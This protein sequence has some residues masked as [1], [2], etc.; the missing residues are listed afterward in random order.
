MIYLLV[1]TTYLLIT[2]SDSVDGNNISGTLSQNVIPKLGSD[3]INSVN[4]DVL[5]GLININNIPDNLN[6][7][8]NPVNDSLIVGLNSSK[9]IG[10]I[11]LDQIVDINFSMIEGVV[12]NNQVGTIDSSKLIGLINQSNIPNITTNKIDGMLN[13]D[14][15]PDIPVDKVSGIITDDKIQSVNVTKIIGEIPIKS[16]EI[17]GTRTHPGDG[18]IL[19][20][21]GIYELITVS[22]KR[23]SFN[24]G[25]ECSGSG[26]FSKFRLSLSQGTNS[27]LPVFGASGFLNLLQIES[28]NSMNFAS[29]FNSF[30]Y[31]GNNAGYFLLNITSTAP[32]TC[33]LHLNYYLVI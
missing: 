13:I 9:L 16:Y 19:L 18:S 20:W 24:G 8:L 33:D 6:S 27:Y 4:S 25:V 15:M 12:E 21:V 28:I 10:T 26:T 30:R 32:M 31:S 1:I 14:Q 23:W 2:K 22:E 5:V 17:L 7:K 29:P 3:K 11:R